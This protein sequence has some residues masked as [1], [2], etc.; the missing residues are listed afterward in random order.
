MENELMRVALIGLGNIMFCDEGVGV[1]LAKYIESNYDFENQ[2][3]IVDGGLL[4]FWLMRYLNSY[5]A[6]IIVG[7]SSHEAKVGA[8][9]VDDKDKILALGQTRK[10]ANEAELVIMLEVAALAGSEANVEMIG[11]VPEDTLSVSN[12]L[13]D[14]M[15]DSFDT[16]VKTTSEVL[17]KY[18]ITLKQKSTTIP[19]EEIVNNY[20]NLKMV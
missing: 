1:Y 2:L 19:I 8:I 16:L 12:A 6:V 4:G 9:T 10:S 11:I 13:S 3:E 15:Y 18:G 20:A 17:K 7:A 5:D 14:A